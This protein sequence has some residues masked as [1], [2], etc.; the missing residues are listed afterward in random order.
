MSGNGTST[1]WGTP[2]TPTVEPGRAIDNAVVIDWAVPTHSIAESTPIPSVSSSTRAVASSPRAS[3]MSVAPN[4]R[5]SA[6]RA[7]LRLR[8]MIRSA[9]SRCDGEDGGEADG[10]VTDDGDGVAPLDAGADGG[11]VAGRHHVGQGQQRAQHGVGVAGAGDRDEGAVGERDADGFA[12]AAVDG[13]VAEV[14]AGDAADRRAVAGS[15]G[16][17]RRCR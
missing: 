3:M 2:T 1:S 13:A 11:V 5:A 15:A 4:V 12:L 16:R 14:A 10:A 17:C 7:G 8:A 9:P 6:W